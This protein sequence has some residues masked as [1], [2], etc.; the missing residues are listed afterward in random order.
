MGVL[1]EALR[2]LENSCPEVELLVVGRGDADE[3]K[4]SAGS[5]LADRLVLLGQADDETKARVLRSVDVYCAP[6]TGGESFGG[7]LTQAMS[8]GAPGGASDP[9][10]VRPGLDD[11][12]GRRRPPV[13][14]PAAPGHPPPALPRDSP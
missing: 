6:N 4:R 9:D 11:G 10:A 14:G 2:L 8:A 13:R 1:L 7:I 3:L 12:P 5:G